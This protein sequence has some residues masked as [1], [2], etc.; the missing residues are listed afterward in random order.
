VSS[1][2]YGVVNQTVLAEVRTKVPLPNDNKS[3]PIGTIA[4][5]TEFLRKLGLEKFFNGLKQRGPRMFPLVCALIS[6]RLTE[7]FSVEGCGRWLSSKEVRKELNLGCEVSSRMLNRAVE[8]AGE[9]LEDALIFLRD[10]LFSSYD[11][12]HTDVNVDSTSISVYSKQTDLFKFGYSRDKRPDLRQVN[13]CVTELREPINIPIHMTVE[14]GNNTDPAVFLRSVNDIIDELRENSLFVFDAGGDSKNVSDLILSKGKRYIVRKKMNISD[15]LWISKF[16]KD[17]AVCVNEGE[18]IFCNARTFTSSGR[19]VYLF[20]SE[21][22]YHDKM[23]ILDSRAQM[24]VDDA[25]ETMKRKR[26]GTL[27]ISRT[28]IKRLRNPLISLNVGVQSKLLSSDEESF[29]YVRNVLSNGREGFFKLECSEKLTPS[30]VL[31][32]YRKRDSVEK[33]I[34]SLKNQID[35]KPLRV[36][37]ENSVKGIL[38][39]AFL[40]QTIVSMMRYEVPELRKRSTKFIIDSLE[41]LTVTYVYDPRG[42]ARRIYSNFEPINSSIL[43]GVAI[44]YAV[45]GG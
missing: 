15:D 1:L 41:N 27:R 22:L 38:F 31:K 33:L 30:D 8:R 2:K 39:L 29:Q 20:F 36:W 3:L 28:V 35:L 26:D 24:C 18:G 4:A 44:K 14:S 25:K 19:T 17:E 10:S 45:S 32:I 43:R 37:S 9:N 6:Y 7:N 21:K 23:A 42:A 13:V 11:L 16:N 40:A 12:E 5:V 34:D